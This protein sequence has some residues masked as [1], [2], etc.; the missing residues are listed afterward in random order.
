MKLNPRWLVL[1]A[2][3]L[4]LGTKLAVGQNSGA[5]S[6]EIFSTGFEI[7][8]GYDPELTLAG[9]N[10]WTNFG[11]GGN[12]LMTIANLFPDQG[13]QAYLGFFPPTDT[14]DVVNVWRPLAF[15][16]VPAATPIVTF[17]VQMAIVDSSTTD[18]D[19]FRWSVYNTNGFRLFSIDFDNTAL[20]VSYALDDG[21]GF[22]PTGVGFTNE[23]VYELTIALDFGRNIWSAW[24]DDTPLVEQVLITTVGSALNLGDI[25]AV[26]YIRDPAAPGDNFMVFDNYRVTAESPTDPY[27][28]PLFETLVR[29][30]DGQVLLGLYAESSQSYVLEASSDFRHW[31]YVGTERASRGWVEFRDRNAPTFPRRFY[32]VRL[33]P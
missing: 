11:T 3:L 18:R 15:A 10:G 21:A 26:W 8:E 2:L 31:Y 1:P 25:D 30:T 9:Q 4:A 32:R 19:D 12:G 20:L 33:V 29:L 16:P 13:Q 6:L 22:F 7:E 27:R 17:S 23:T 28:P 24:L 14:N 5:P